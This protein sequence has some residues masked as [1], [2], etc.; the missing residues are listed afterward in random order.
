V[1]VL[2]N[3]KSYSEMLRIV[4]WS[5]LLIARKVASGTHSSNGIPNGG[6]K[7]AYAE[8]HSIYCH[9]ESGLGRVIFVATPVIIPRINDLPTDCAGFCEIVGGDCSPSLSYTRMLENRKG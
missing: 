6:M 5:P 3:A 2:V 1:A 8:L 7:G 4:G 9:I